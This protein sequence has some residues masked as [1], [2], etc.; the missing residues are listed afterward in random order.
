MSETLLLE[1]YISER[2]SNAKKW[3]VATEQQLSELYKKEC[4]LWGQYRSKQDTS[5]MQSILCTIT[6]FLGDWHNLV[7]KLSVILRKQLIETK[8]LLN[9]KSDINASSLD[10]DIYR[11]KEEQTLKDLESMKSHF[12]MLRK[13]KIELQ[14]LLKSFSSNNSANLLGREPEIIPFPFSF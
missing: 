12:A 9:A 6:A 10:L 14:G 4:D 11:I 7:L 13:K 1:S 5:K 8:S 3:L 2:S